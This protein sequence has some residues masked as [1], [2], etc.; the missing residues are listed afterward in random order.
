MVGEIGRAKLGDKV[1]GQ[2]RGKISGAKSGDK[3]GEQ[4]P[5]L[6]LRLVWELLRDPVGVCCA[7][8]EPPNSHI[9]QNHVLI[10]CVF[11]I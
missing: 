3:I 8:L 2:N 11:P 4:N 6:G 5:E 9:V 7:P 1:G 10:S